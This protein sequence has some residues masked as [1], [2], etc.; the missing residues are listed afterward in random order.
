[1]VLVLDSFLGLRDLRALSGVNMFY[2]KVM[3]EMSRLLLLDLRPLLDRDESTGHGHVFGSKIRSGTW[4]SSQTSLE[5]TTLV[6]G[7]MSRPYSM[8][9]NLSSA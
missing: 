1:M 5:V 4:K 9:S 6:P 7:G 3:P 2:N 8:E